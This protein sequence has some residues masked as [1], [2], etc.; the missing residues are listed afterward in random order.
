M[1]DFDTLQ[2]TV[3]PS[4]IKQSRI[5]VLCVCQLPTE[6]RDRTP[7]DVVKRAH[8]AFNLGFS[9]FPQFGEL[10]PYEG[11]VWQVR[12][13]IQFPKRYKSKGASYQA[14]ASLIWIGSYESIEDV[15]NDYL[16]LEVKE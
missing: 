6:V 11:Q 8:G 7:Q 4:S 9:V 12:E 1:S 15:I 2:W 5:Y 10:F 3:K 13:L 14:I 16:N